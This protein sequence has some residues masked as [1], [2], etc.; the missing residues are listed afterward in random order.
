MGYDI[1]Y[2]VGRGGFG[3]VY[4]VRKKVDYKTYA[5]KIENN[6]ARTRRRAMVDE[7]QA[8]RE[9][10]GCD[11][12]P[13]LVDYGFYKGLAF[14]V[15]PLFRYSLKDVLERNPKFFTRKSATILG[16]K[17]LSIIELIHGRGRLYRDIKPENIMFDHNNKIYLIDFGMSM[18]YLE[19][20]GDH[21]P[22]L[23]GRSI[24]GTLWYMSINTHKGVEQSRRDDIESLFYLLILLYKSEL[25]WV[26]VGISMSKRQKT[27][28]QKVKESL[29]IHEL[30]DG[31]SGKEHLIKFFEYVRRLEFLEKPDYRYLNSLLDKVLCYKKEF[32]NYKETDSGE[33]KESTGLIAVS[34]WY[35][36]ISILCPFSIE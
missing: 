5:L 1:H 7:I 2:E 36:L 16:K 31:I 34:L 22:E 3:T 24:S 21:I 17:L 27:K 32:W 18:P 33:I 8:Y 9:L 10:Q 28:T 15:L 25:P 23:R 20:N 12:I 29:S 26:E 4:K 11:G 30:C 14:L 13:H 35:K 6:T 19:D